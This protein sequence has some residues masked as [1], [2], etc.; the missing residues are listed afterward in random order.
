MITRTARVEPDRRDAA[1]DEAGQVVRL[2]RRGAP[3]LRLAVTAASRATSTRLRP[4]TR[5]TIGS[6]RPVLVRG[7]EDQ[8]LD[9]LAEV[10]PDG[11]RRL[12]GRVGRLVE[13]DDLERHALAGGRVED[14]A[15]GR[16]VGAA[17]ARPE[18]TSG[19][20]RSGR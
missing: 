19:R 15:N 9:D 14:A 12:L 7:D 2:A 3:D 10:G 16:V 13:G 1:D 8:R 20:G 11:R 6:W 4:D 18:S 17:G 5:H